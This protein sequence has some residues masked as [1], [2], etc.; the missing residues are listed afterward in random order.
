[1]RTAT[2]ELRTDGGQAQVEADESDDE[3]TEEQAD[4]E[5]DAAD[6]E[7]RD[8][9]GSDETD[10]DEGETQGETDDGESEDDEAATGGESEVE[11]ETSDE[12]AAS[13]ETSDTDEEDESHVEDADDVYES[14]DASGVVHLD[15][16]GLFLDVLGLEVNLNEVTLDVS[17]RPGENNLLGNL[18]SAVS[19]L[20]DGP[21]AVLDSVKSM[22][23]KP[24]EWFTGLLQR[25]KEFLASVP[26][27]A[28]EFLGGFVSRTTE[29]LAGLFGVGGEG[30]EPA[31]EDEAG[32]GEE[33]EADNEPEESAGRISRAMSWLREKLVGV[34]P[35]LPIEE[36]V[37]T[38]VREVLQQVI[39][40]LEPEDD[41]PAGEE[42]A[43]QAEAQS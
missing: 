34:V 17:A 35:G 4:E 2:G 23:A 12:E 7:E 32:A 43:A 42:G 24:K 41:Q 6:G 25:P 22:L 8:T 9:E 31:G 21:S 13:D 5:T 11:D 1:M 37:A 10:A 28:R 3:R 29:F 27:R 33:E 26:T 40:Q 16:E 30:E 19:G 20:L 39:D 36:L 38:V 14:D 15:L 18:L